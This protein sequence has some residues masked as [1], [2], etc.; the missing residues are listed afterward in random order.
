M[1]YTIEHAARIG[2]HRV[3]GTL[4]SGDQVVSGIAIDLEDGVPA[5]LEH[6]V[7]TDDDVV[8]DAVFA[9]AVDAVRGLRSSTL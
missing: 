2:S 3:V 9:A 1:Q 8:L 7:H 5:V 6:G 4:L